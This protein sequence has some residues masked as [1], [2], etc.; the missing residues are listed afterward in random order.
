[1]RKKR[2]STDRNFIKYS[3]LILS[4]LILLFSSSCRKTDKKSIIEFPKSKTPAEDSR[5][6]LEVS[7][8]K[9]QYF[10][11]HICLI[12][13]DGTDFKDLGEAK[14]GKGYCRKGY[15]YSCFHPLF[16]PDRRTIAYLSKETDA[17]TGVGE[18]KPH[19]RQYEI[20]LVSIDGKH[21]TRFSSLLNPGGNETTGVCIT[22]APD[23]KGFYCL[24]SVYQKE[25]GRQKKLFYYVGIDGN[26][27]IIGELSVGPQGIYGTDYFALSPCGK[28]I[29]YT[30]E[31]ISSTP[32]QQGYEQGIE[33]GECLVIRSIENN[34]FGEPI[35][36]YST[37]VPCCFIDHIVWISESELLFLE[38]ELVTGANA[39][40]SDNLHYRHTIW[41]LNTN[42]GDKEMI[43]Q[44]K[45][46]VFAGFV[47][48]FSL[49]PDRNSVAVLFGIDEHIEPETGGFAYGIGFID[50]KTKKTKKF[51]I[52]TGTFLWDLYT[53]Y[54]KGNKS[55][56]I[57]GLNWSSP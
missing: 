12:N 13:T 49:S 3:S 16:S 48:S 43:Y 55:F 44:T 28:Y 30:T 6:L 52:P 51:T 14:R 4:I 22:W 40:I 15:I 17:P 56:P 9:N 23:N 39:V 10:K 20:W 1:M 35:V 38:V 41:K 26:K 19:W 18:W 31:D 32:D 45:P 29:A 53:E 50:I 11:S 47:D 57:S 33:K 54:R 5:L 7:Y 25:E 27:K 8:L 42:N 37:N 24:Q 36:A 21:K 46:H 2:L 34:Q